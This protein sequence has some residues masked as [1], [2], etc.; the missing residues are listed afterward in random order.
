MQTLRST[1]AGRTSANDE[2]VY[3]ALI[4]ISEEFSSRG[5]RLK[6]R[7]EAE[8]TTSAGRECST[9]SSHCFLGHGG[10]SL[11]K[12]LKTRDFL[13]GVAGKV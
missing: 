12:L 9:G 5:L 6:G 1:E 4:G 10:F 7:E 8:A 3:V 2:N 11:K 13:K